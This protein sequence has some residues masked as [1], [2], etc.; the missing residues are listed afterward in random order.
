MKSYPHGANRY[1][2]QPS[3]LFAGQL[4]K[5]IENQRSPIN[6]GQPIDGLVQPCVVLAPFELV[7]RSPGLRGHEIG[8]VLSEQPLAKLALAPSGPYDALGDAEKPGIDG[9]LASKLE[10]LAERD[11]ENVV[12]QILEVGGGPG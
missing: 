3:H 12:H 2:S 9:G 4:F 8:L 10:P 11:E 7:L 6:V 1:P 5:L